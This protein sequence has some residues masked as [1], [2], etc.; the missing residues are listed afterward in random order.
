M[1]IDL[2]YPHSMLCQIWIHMSCFPG[3]PSY[4]DAAAADLGRPEAARP[5]RRIATLS[6]LANLCAQASVASPADIPS[7]LAKAD[8]FRDQ[9]YIAY[10]AAELMLDELRTELGQAP[11]P[12]KS[13]PKPTRRGRDRNQ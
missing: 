9:L 7:I 4:L 12:T 5:A 1:G 10:W 13:T 2:P 3:Y 6:A 11:S 8:E